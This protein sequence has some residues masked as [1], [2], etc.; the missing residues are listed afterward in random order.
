MRQPKNTTRTSR[1][2]PDRSFIANTVDSWGG[3]LL[4]CRDLWDGY[5]LSDA[6]LDST[7]LKKV[8]WAT[9]FA[10]MHRRFGP[11]NDGGD[12]FKDLTAHWIINS[13]DPDV[14][15]VVNPA[16]SGPGFSVAPYLRASASAAGQVP[17]ASEMG[18]HPDRV[19]AIQVAYKATLLDLLRPVS[20]RDRYINALG[21]M[22]NSALDDAL[23]GNGEGDG[24]NA[25]ELRFH[26]SSGYSMP[27]GLF[28]GSDWP[29]F[30]AL[31]RQLGNGD[32]AVGRARVI[33]LLQ[34]E[35]YTEGAAAGWPV[36]RL[37]LLGAFAQRE[38][39]AAG[40]G[41]GAEGVARFEAEMSAI[42][43]RERPERSTIDEMTD[44]AV[45][46]A[47]GLLQRLGLGYKDLEKTV[48]NMRHDKAVT[49]AWSELVAIAKDDFPDDA[50]LPRDPYG[51][52]NELS[53]TLKAEFNR[54]GRGELAN[55]VDR[56]VARPSG[57]QALADIAYH[58]AEEASRQ[59]SSGVPAV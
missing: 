19:T 28:G 17:C 9:L 30:C 21:E 12:N 22:G 56:T 27:L 55:W 50:A 35:A 10:Y 57:L 23:L 25:Y 33:E 4:E 7:P 11:P 38:A 47:T 8:H 51:K 13:P 15:V 31:L 48:R 29:T 36:Q 39:V 46:T 58:L 52:G 3:R 49:E 20:V 59:R 41:L 40:L 2:L 42:R 24:D 34:R 37:L 5:A 26:A 16:L 45:E 18:L 53:A 6:V 54:L 43:D 1:H 32:H 44:A 14:F